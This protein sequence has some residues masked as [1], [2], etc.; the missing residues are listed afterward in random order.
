MN[1]RSRIAKILHIESPMLLM[2]SLIIAIG[3]WA[4]VKTHMG[5]E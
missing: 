5:M 2:I 3:I 1:L 4:W